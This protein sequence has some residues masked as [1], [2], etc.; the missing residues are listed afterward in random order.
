[1]SSDYPKYAG[2]VFIDPVPELKYKIK[3]LTE[4]VKLLEDALEYYSLRASWR[5]SGSDRFDCNIN[6][7]DSSDIITGKQKERVGGKRA[8]AALEQLKIMRGSH[9]TSA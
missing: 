8:R 6:Y 5:Y 1:M 9:G 2:A 3:S 4:Q 7:E